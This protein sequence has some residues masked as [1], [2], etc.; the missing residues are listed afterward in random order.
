MKR[1]RG[2]LGL[3]AQIDSWPHPRRRANNQSRLLLLACVEV[4]KIEA[5]A[6]AAPPQVECTLGEINVTGPG[7][8]VLRVGERHARGGKGW[9]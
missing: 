9:K 2:Q 1:G 5:L 6:V 7:R 8:E 4:P 3:G